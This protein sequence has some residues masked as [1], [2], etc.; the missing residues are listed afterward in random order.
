LRICPDFLLTTYHSH[1]RK[2]LSHRDFRGYFSHSD[3]LAQPEKVKSDHLFFVSDPRCG[4]VFSGWRSK[5]DHLPL[6]CTIFVHRKTVETEAES[7]AAAIRLFCHFCGQ[8]RVW[9]SA[10]KNAFGCRLRKAKCSACY[11]GEGAEREGK[12][13]PVQRPLP[14][15]QW[16]GTGLKTLCMSFYARLCKLSAGPPIAAFDLR[17]LKSGNIPHIRVTKQAESVVGCGGRRLKP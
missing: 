7:P 14:K 15:L 16:E 11:N 8:K 12:L 4:A 1:L 2:R 9:A 13:R 5:S 3:H 10:R 6:S 17:R